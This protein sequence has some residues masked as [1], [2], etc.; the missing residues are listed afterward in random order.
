MHVSGQG[1]FALEGAHGLPTAQQGSRRPTRRGQFALTPLNAAVTIRCCS[2]RRSRR[3]TGARCAAELPG[4]EFVQFSRHG[5]HNGGLAVSKCRASASAVAR[6]PHAAPPA[7][8]RGSPAAL[9]DRTLASLAALR[10][11]CVSACYFCRAINPATRCV[12]VLLCYAIPASSGHTERS[13]AVCL[14]PYPPQAAQ[15][16]PPQV[17]PVSSRLVDEGV[18]AYPESPSPRPSPSDFPE[19]LRRPNESTWPRPTRPG[20]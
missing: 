18:G 13:T 16:Q 6:S 12:R 15:A 3:P 11:A 14:I 9:A 10:C 20:L 1:S 19:R 2:A 7:L 8:L 5:D 4:F 17:S